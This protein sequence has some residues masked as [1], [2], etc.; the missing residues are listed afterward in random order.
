MV[1]CLDLLAPVKLGHCV[2]PIVSEM[3]RETSHAPRFT[4]RRGT[5]PKVCQT[6]G[7]ERFF[8]AS[9]MMSC[10]HT[11]PQSYKGLSC[12]PHTLCAF[13]SSC[14]PIKETPF[15]LSLSKDRIATNWPQPR[16]Q[17]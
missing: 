6:W 5:S 3:G 8:V 17:L 14:E 2:W 12:L 9:G 7:Q 15:V 13:A 1:Q 4:L 10:L 16:P 11:K